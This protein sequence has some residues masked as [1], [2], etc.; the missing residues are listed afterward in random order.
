MKL[1]LKGRFWSGWYTAILIIAGLIFV[2]LELPQGYS[3]DLSVIGQG[4]NVVVVIHDSK[5]FPS[6]EFLSRM[7]EIRDEYRG[8]IAFC[9]A[10]IT[11]KKGAAFA[12]EQKTIP[13]SLLLFAAD[14]SRLGEIKGG[15]S[16]EVVRDAIKQIFQ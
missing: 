1:K 10:D 12:A 8:R 11:D 4:Q 7:N 3:D 13:P 2:V 6:V 9:V 15:R 16:S 14:G 5:K